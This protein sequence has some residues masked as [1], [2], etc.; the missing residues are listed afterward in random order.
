MTASTLGN[1][2]KEAWRAFGR[3]AALPSH[4]SPSIPILFFGNLQAYCTS[5]TR[6]LTVGL[7][8]SLH[9]FPADSPFRRFPLAEGVTVSEPGRYLDALSAYFRTEPYRGWFSA[10]GPLLNGLEASYY[11]G[12]ASTVLHTDICSPVATNPTWSGLD[13]SVQKYLERDGNPLWHSLLRVLRPQM[14]IISVACRHLSHIRFK[15]LGE[16]RIL[17]KFERTQ[18]GA[19]RKHPVAISTRRYDIGGEPSLLVFLPA[20]QKPLGRLGSIQKREAGVI[21]LEE[22]HRGG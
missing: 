12:Q 15:A 5:K 10:F 4:V 17:R 8:P 1:K 20:A 11:E 13:P 21:A 18:A 16:W 9:E 14:V 6:V 2:V 3:A 19:P 22:L 7:N